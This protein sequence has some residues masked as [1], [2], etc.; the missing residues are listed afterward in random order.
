MEPEYGRRLELLRCLSPHVMMPPA[1]AR[2]A[3]DTACAP[4][5]CGT[6]AAGCEGAACDS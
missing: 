2:G 3:R 4:A 5:Q 1:R 6:G